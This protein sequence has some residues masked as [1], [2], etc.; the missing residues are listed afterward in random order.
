MMPSEV[1][2][3]VPE[4]PAAAQMD[5]LAFVVSPLAR[6]TQPRFYGIERLPDRGALNVGNHTIYSFLDHLHHPPD[7]HC[8]DHGLLES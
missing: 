6:V 3:R 8:D 2:P 7:D 4:A 1:T 5:R